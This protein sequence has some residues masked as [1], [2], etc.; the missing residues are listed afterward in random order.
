MAKRT[1]YIPDDLDALIEMA[2]INISNICQEAL[3]K[4]VEEHPYP[5]S[6]Q[7]WPPPHI[8]RWLQRKTTHTVPLV[9]ELRYW[10]DY[11]EQALAKRDRP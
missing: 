4:R 8:Q 11:L 6:G 7:S 5:E 2:D 9:I 10:A 1:I 3:Q